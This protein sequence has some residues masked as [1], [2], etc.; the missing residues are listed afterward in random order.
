MLSHKGVLLGI[1]VVVAGIAGILYAMVMTSPASETGTENGS[2]QGVAVITDILMGKVAES[3]QI[4]R[5]PQ[6]RRQST[7]TIGDQ[8][9][10]QTRT[11][12]GYEGS[13]TLGVR[14]LE[15][16]TGRIVQLSPSVVSLDSGFSTYCCW[17]LDRSGDFSFQ[18]SR[19]NGTL[20]S[21]PLRI[22]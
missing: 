14:M 10:V 5:N 18:V 16:G 2:G 13:V 7:Y 17:T 12:S 1:G 15:E 20:T 8:I 21:F 11:R 9:A 19:P 3:D 4:G 6:L 22:R